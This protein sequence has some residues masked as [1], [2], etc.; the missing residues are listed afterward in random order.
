M[1]STPAPARQQRSPDEV[2]DIILRKILLVSL[3]PPSSPNPAVAYLE[4]TAAELLSESRPLLALRD[5][6]ER[7]IIGRLSIP[8]QPAN[9]P[10]PFAF[11]AAAFRRAAD[12]ARKITT[13]RDA[14]LQ[15]RLKA[16]IAH[17]RANGFETLDVTPEAEE[18]WVQEVIANRGKT[19]RN[20]ECTPGYYNFEGNSNRRQDGNYNGGFAAYIDHVHAVE[21]A[22]D[23]SFIFTR[24]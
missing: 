3:T 1:A 11:L 2:E 10:P 18:M 14:G 9:S 19:N 7:I 13:I 24:G 15:A 20:A 4:L 17:T 8:D 23:E 21:A 22:M 6:A 5:N 12:E 16:S